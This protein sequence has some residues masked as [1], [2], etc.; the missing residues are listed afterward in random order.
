MKLEFDEPRLET[1][2][3]RRSMRAESGEEACRLLAAHNEIRSVHIVGGGSLTDDEEQ[4]I[5]AL[6][7]AAQTSMAVGRRGAIALRHAP[8]Q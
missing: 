8:G 5:A 4:G 2:R 3:L 7:E 1:R 6:A